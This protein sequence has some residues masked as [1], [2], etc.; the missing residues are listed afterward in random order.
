MHNTNG[1][2]AKADYRTH[3]AK[4]P[5]FETAP[6]HVSLSSI[7]EPAYLGAPVSVATLRVCL[8]QSSVADLALSMTPA[9]KNANDAG[10]RC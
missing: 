9:S 8:S 1:A 2:P 6:R 5:P 4:C 10:S 3:H 7:C